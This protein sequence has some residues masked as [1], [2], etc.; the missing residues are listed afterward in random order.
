MK[1]E[2]ISFLSFAAKNKSLD[3]DRRET[4]VGLRARRRRRYVVEMKTS[5]GTYYE[6]FHTFACLADRFLTAFNNRDSNFVFFLVSFFLTKTKQ[7]YG[8]YLIK[9][10]RHFRATITELI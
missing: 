7:R 9:R 4:V 1:F 10:L 2:S 3:D 6:H 8:L 5:R